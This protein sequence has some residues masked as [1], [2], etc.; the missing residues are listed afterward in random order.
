MT[1]Q[2][3]AAGLLAIGIAMLGLS[4][5]LRSEIQRAV[6]LL[7]AAGSIGY[8]WLR[9][10]RDIHSR[11]GVLALGAGADIGDDFRRFHRL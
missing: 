5:T 1:R 9:L 7:I 4:L 3:A 8:G 6:V 2:L 11:F 10:R